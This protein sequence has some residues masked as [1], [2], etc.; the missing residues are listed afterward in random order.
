MAQMDSRKLIGIKNKFWE[1]SWKVD[2]IPASV[3]G[4][5][6]LLFTWSNI[7]IFTNSLK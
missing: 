4:V 3:V 5:P 7:V 6:V 1:S 2:G